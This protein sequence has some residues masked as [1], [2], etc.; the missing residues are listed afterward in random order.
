M[1]DE[2][3]GPRAVLNEEIALQKTF[4][5]ERFSFKEQFCAIFNPNRPPLRPFEP[6]STPSERNR[7]CEAAN[8][9]RCPVRRD[10]IFAAAAADAALL[11]PPRI[12]ILLPK[13]ARA[14]AAIEESTARPLLSPLPRSPSR[15]SGSSN[16]SSVASDLTRRSRHFQS[17]FRSGTWSSPPSPAKRLNAHWSFRSCITLSKTARNTASASSCRSRSN[18]CPAPYLRPPST[19]RCPMVD[20]IPH[21]KLEPELH[22]PP[23]QARFKPHHQ[24]SI[25]RRALMKKLKRI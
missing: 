13:P 16:I 11:G 18:K 2:L 25:N 1:L 20:I 4:F 9:S 21:E 8:D 24:R 17:V 15:N 7:L 5:R 14:G 6:R 22:L 12:D 23:Q 10:V 19:D 3:T